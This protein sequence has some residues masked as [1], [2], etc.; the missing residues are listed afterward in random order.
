[1]ISASL[2]G[3]SNL[4]LYT[5][6]PTPTSI[7]LL[8]LNSPGSGGL[9]AAKLISADL[10]DHPRYHTLSYTWGNPIMPKWSEISPP[11][12]AVL[13][14]DGVRH[15]T[16]SNLD[17]ALRTI[18]S[19]RTTMDLMEQQPIWIDAVCIDQAD[20]LE[21]N[22]QVAMMDRIYS[23]AS[24]VVSWLGPADEQSNK[25]IAL[26]QNL[27]KGLWRDDPSCETGILPSKFIDQKMRDLKDSDI[28]P[29]L[30][31]PA[32]QYFSRCWI[33]QE[34]FLAKRS[35]FLHGNE[36]ICFDDLATISV[37]LAD[38][39]NDRS[40]GTTWGR[41][42]VQYGFGNERRVHTLP[43]LQQTMQRERALICFAQLLEAARSADCFDPRDKVFAL[44]G[45]PPRSNSKSRLSAPDYNRSIE[46]NL[47]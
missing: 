17:S 35:R 4:F 10:A 25:V 23:T 21:R 30:H 36:E 1:M 27:F 26:M 8:K 31:L 28:E 18:L 46:S 12:Y 24:L 13:L 42:A 14:C 20:L 45:L 2:D 43:K 33:L 16:T 15:Q 19:H 34:V 32:R 6:L 37:L 3:Q 39:R 47:Q 5:P 29:L 40:Y 44:Q 38:L 9:L 11:T 7:R 41:G 22:T